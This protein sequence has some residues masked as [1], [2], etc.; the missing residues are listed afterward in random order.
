MG[1]KVYISGQL[2]DKE[3]A[4]ISVYDHGFLYGDGVFEGLRSYRGKVFRLEQHLDR[5]WHSAKAIRLEIPM[6][7][8]ELAKAVVDTL[9]VNKIEDGYI[10]LVVSRGSG[11]LGLDPN[12][13]SDPQVV[14]ITDH[15]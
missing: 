13:T 5:L 8:A 10:R 2:Y 6:A 12:R 3:D 4:K 1:L 9:K 7:R 11:S 14:I 15:I